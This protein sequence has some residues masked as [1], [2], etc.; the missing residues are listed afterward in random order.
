M[1]ESFYINFKLLIKNL[2]NL[3][4]ANNFN[5]YLQLDLI[6]IYQLI[7]CTNNIMIKMRWPNSEDMKPP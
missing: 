6:I 1:I 7:N 3:F 2:D 4:I 5:Y